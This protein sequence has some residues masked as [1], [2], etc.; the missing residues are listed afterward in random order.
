MK[1]LFARNL[2]PRLVQLVASIYPDSVH[3][4]DIGL[5]DADDSAEYRKAR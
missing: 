3:V 2:P 5:S 4:L 1:L